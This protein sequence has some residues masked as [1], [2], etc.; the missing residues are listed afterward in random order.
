MPHLPGA[1]AYDAPG[2]YGDQYD[3]GGPAVAPAPVGDDAVAYCLQT[4]GSYDPQSGTYVGD[5]GY[6]HP[7]P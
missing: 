3:D 5:D 4:Y 2:Y 7:C 1:P 6:R